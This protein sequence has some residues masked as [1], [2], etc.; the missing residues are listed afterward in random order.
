VTS[1]PKEYYARLL[2]NKSLQVTLAMIVAG[3]TVLFTAV[4]V[5]EVQQGHSWYAIG[6]PLCLIGMGFLVFPKTE[7]WI[8]KP[9][10]AKPEQYE[11]HIIG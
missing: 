3:L 10:Q 8:Y 11:K 1:D 7:E 9:W 2:V 5:A 4:I 6:L